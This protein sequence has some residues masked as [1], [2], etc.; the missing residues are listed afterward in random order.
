MQKSKPF[1]SNPELDRILND[2]SELLIPLQSQIQEKFTET[3]WPVTLII[4][5]PRSGT[6]LLL[7]ILSSVGG[8]SYPT[9]L[10]NR[11]AY[12]PYIGAL[13]QRI[14]FD[15]ACDYQDQF[16]DLQSKVNFISNLGTSKGALATNEFQYFFR[17]FMP[18]QDDGFIEIDNLS[19]VNVKGII[20]GFAS[21]ESVFSK[22][23]ICKGIL[24]QNN[25]DFFACA[26]PKTIF[27]A[28]DRDPL[29][30]MQSLYF[31]RKKYTDSIFHW[32]SLKPKEYPMI[33]NFTIYEQIAAQVF[34]LKKAINEGLKTLPDNRKIIFSYDEVC[35]SPEKIY[36][37]I[38]EKYNDL[39]YKFSW[40]SAK[41]PEFTPQ[42]DIKITD[43][44]RIKFIRAY[45]SMNDLLYS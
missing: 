41:F 5:V 13:I 34:C 23:F 30:N 33:K 24:L 36:E 11:F 44:E 7:Q 40:P 19:S 4:G 8:F 9:N 16:E 21:I 32:W 43:S 25:L 1:R 39:G 45:E 26:L 35:N 28:V 27:V 31:A 29:F 2:L 42:K 6:T 22:P 18:K 14:L 10:I 38:I 12:L 37:C 15:P 3:A 17:N 20:S